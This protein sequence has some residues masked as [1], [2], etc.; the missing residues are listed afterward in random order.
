MSSDET[1]ITELW[2]TEVPKLLI[3]LLNPYMLAYNQ[4]SFMHKS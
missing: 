4:G 1:P 2:G 3:A